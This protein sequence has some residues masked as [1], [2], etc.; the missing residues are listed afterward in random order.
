MKAGTL[1]ND[2]KD[3]KRIMNNVMNTNLTITYTK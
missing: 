3:M 2:P 1:L